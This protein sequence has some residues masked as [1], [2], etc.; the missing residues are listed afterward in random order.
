MNF[1][2]VDKVDFA[3]YMKETTPA[4]RLKSSQVYLDDF[5]EWLRTDSTQKH[6]TMIWPKSHGQMAFR[7]GEVTVW[8]GFNGSGK[9]L[10]TG[11]VQLG[12]IA[13]QERCAVFSL[14]M[15]P[16]RLLA[17]QLRQFVGENFRD[18][19]F[20]NHDAYLNK[21]VAR[22][23]EFTG[24]RLWIW[25]QFG[26]TNAET[27]IGAI[28]YCAKEL[29]I[30]QV[31]VDN[32]SKVV[33]GDDDYDGQKWFI[34]VMCQIAMDQ[35]IHIH[36]VHHLKKTGSIEAMPSFQDVKG[37]GTITD[38]PDNI[39]LIHRNLKKERD[40]KLGKPVDHEEFDTMLMVEKQRNA[41]DID[42]EMYALYYH[43]QSTQFLESV[44]GLP[45]TFDRGAAW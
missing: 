44:S 9:T 45:F 8:A 19:R 6:P 31:F 37:S 5:P 17:R 34:G 13:Q 21:I 20:Q 42:K 25:D 2:S 14:E 43:A 30:D 22:M 29:A 40:L 32:L 38:Q 7:P 41:D 39:I 28:L 36:V 4:Q 27:I 33:Q 11:Q 24:D 15:K 18:P 35:G 26:D 3:A 12:L 23:S 10:I 16:R 1:L